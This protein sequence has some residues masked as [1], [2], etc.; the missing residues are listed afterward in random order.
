MAISSPEPS[1]PLSSG[2]GKRRRVED[3]EDEY[4]V[5]PFRWTRVTRALGTRLNLVGAPSR[6]GRVHDLAMAKGLSAG[7]LLSSSCQ[8]QG[9]GEGGFYRHLH[10]ARLGDLSAK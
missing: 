2:T 3:V 10:L 5:F 4:F 1:L 9:E 6:L 8:K 7:G